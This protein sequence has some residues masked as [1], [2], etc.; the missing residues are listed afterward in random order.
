[1]WFFDQK[2]PSKTLKVFSAEAV[3]IKKSAKHAENY[4]QISLRSSL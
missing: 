3:N 1:M 2:N 4:G